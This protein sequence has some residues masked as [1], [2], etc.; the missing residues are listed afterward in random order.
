MSHHLV[1]FVSGHQHLG[2]ALNG[3]SCII[4][5]V[6]ELSTV[7][8]PQRREPVRGDVLFDVSILA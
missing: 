4:V 2:S 5:F 3:V 8:T 7:K 1:V 6:S